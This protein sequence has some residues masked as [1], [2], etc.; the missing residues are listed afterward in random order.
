VL[1]PGQQ[2]GSR[3]GRLAGWLVGWLATG[4]LGGVLVGKEAEEALALGA[5]PAQLRAVP[6]GSER[7]GRGELWFSP[8]T[9]PA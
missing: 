3:T 2:A 6:A 7:E 5:R 8:L 1:L 9:C 4:L